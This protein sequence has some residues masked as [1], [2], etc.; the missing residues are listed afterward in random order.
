M[1]K[2]KERM[3]S[4]AEIKVSL[5]LV[6]STERNE[7]LHILLS[8]SSKGKKKREEGRVKDKKGRGVSIK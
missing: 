7:K 8:Y 5:F 2:G 1:E 6:R 4:R 3:I